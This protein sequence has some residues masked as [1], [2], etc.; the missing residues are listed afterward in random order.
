MSEGAELSISQI[1]S[2]ESWILSVAD[3]RGACAAPHWL[4]ADSHSRGGAGH[5]VTC[6]TERLGPVIAVIADSVSG[7]R[8]LL[9]G[10]EER[11]PVQFISDSEY[12]LE[13]MG[14]LLR[15]ACRRTSGDRL[16]YVSL[17]PKEF[18]TLHGQSI[19]FL[20]PVLV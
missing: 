10:R 12:L 11:G 6:S 3:E 20:A 7:M 14:N 1:V 2:E 16:F 19:M 18:V 13:H 9:G 4:S 5:P 17:R 15:A 8:F